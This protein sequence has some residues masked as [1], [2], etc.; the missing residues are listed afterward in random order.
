M[1]KINNSNCTY[2]IQ[3]LTHPFGFKGA[4]SSCIWTVEVKLESHE[5]KAS[6]SSIQ[7]VLWSDGSLY[8]SIKEQK[9][10]EYMFNITSYVCE[11]LIGMCFTHP[12]DLFDN[13]FQLAIN[14][15]HSVLHI[16]PRKT[17]ILNALVPIDNAIRMLY[18]RYKGIYDFEHFASIETMSDIKQDKLALIPLITYGTSLDQIKNLA[19]SGVCIFKIKIGADPDN[20]NDMSKMLNQDKKRL[21]QIHDILK[22]YKTIYTDTG[23]VAYY[24][25]ANGRYDT[26][27]RMNQLLDYAKEIG[28]FERIVLL[29][30]PF[31]ENNDID[32]SN[33]DI[34]VAA[35]ESVHDE[36]DAIRKI[37]RGYN[38][39]ALKPIAKTLTVT[40][41]VTKIALE[42]GIDVFCAD[43]TVTPMLVEINK[44]Y[45]ARLPA[46][47]GMKIGIIESNGAQNY[48]NWEAMMEKHP[49]KDDKFTKPDNGLFIL[50]DTFYSSSGGIFK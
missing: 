4:Y 27:D 16:F 20:D 10:N 36:A 24:L 25:D 6:G 44:N 12:E 19:E 30:E 22:Q 34:T 3:P 2:Q 17:F 21:L 26:I 1:I 47:K 37:E 35:D 46:I 8:S 9:A 13:I 42:N 28:A 5:T 48:A 45:A 15:A 29:E 18:S 38:A 50:D 49:L 14:Y 31:D 32:V 33:L 7:G 11:K 39:F 40:N 41:K 23:Y 43:L